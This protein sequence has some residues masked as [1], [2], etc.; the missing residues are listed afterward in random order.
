LNELLNIIARLRNTQLVLVGD[1]NLNL[2]DLSLPETVEFV[3]IL[4]QF[5]LKQHVLLL[6]PWLGWERLWVVVSWT[7]AI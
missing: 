4:E 6:W 1:L 7:G 5:G 2:M 3:E